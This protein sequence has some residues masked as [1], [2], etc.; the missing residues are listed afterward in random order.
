MFLK[1]TRSGPR[2]YLQLVEAFRVRA[3]VKLLGHAFESINY[4]R[5]HNL[6]KFTPS[7]DRRIQAGEQVFYDNIVKLRALDWDLPRRM[8]GE[9]FA[10]DIVIALGHAARALKLMTP[11]NPDIIA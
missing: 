7:Q 10:S 2:Q 5:L 3:Q 8:L 6:V 11:Q 9:K 1:I 4:A